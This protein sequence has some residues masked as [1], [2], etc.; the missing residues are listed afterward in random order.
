MVASRPPPRDASP[1]GGR[2]IVSIAY[3]LEP[4]PVA[5]TEQGLARLPVISE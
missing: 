4:V 3:E 5:P 1:V 2:R